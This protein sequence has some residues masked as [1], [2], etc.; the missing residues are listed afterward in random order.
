MYLEEKSIPAPVVELE[1]WR[2]STLDAADYI[3]K[4][5]WCQ[6]R[7]HDGEKVCAVGA[8]IAVSPDLKVVNT[9]HEKL[10]EQVGEPI[11]L[12]NDAPNRTAT[13]VTAVMRACA[14]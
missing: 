2:Q 14:R 3:D 8:L 13:E 7:L 5:G 1:P 6:N 10:I 11:T 4:R 12:W 9:A